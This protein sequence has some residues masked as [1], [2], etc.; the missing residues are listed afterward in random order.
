[1]EEHVIGWLCRQ[2][3][4]AGSID[5]ARQ[6]QMRAAQAAVDPALL[7]TGIYDAM[8]PKP[9]HFPCSFLVFSL[10]GFSR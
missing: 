1:M 10:M 7:A 6:A 4:L 3:A 5:S 2:V 9:L 8:D